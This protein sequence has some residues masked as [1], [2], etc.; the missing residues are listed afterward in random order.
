M[1]KF[2]VPRKIKKKLKKTIWLYP[3]DNK[4][5]S[6]MAF[7]TRNQKDY[8]AFRQGLVKSI[9]EKDNKEERKKRRQELDK[10]IEISDTTLQE[11]VNDYF[12]EQYRVVSFYI[13]REAKRSPKARIAYYNFVNEYQLSKKEN[14]DSSILGLIVDHAEK[15]L[16]ETKQ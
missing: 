12:A 9:L 10:A 8:T 4:G 14:K 11:Y 15:L 13:L 3:S 7:P 5:N 2:R 6:L 1:T 16:R